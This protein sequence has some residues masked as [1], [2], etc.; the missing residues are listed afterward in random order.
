[1]EYVC[2]RCKQEV[3][4]TA[5]D[6]GGCGKPLA[7]IPWLAT[8]L[9]RARETT[10]AV[11]V[12]YMRR[13]FPLQMV[14]VALAWLAFLPLGAWMT[15]WARGALEREASG[16]AEVLAAMVEREVQP[17]LMDLVSSLMQV[18]V[19]AIE[20]MATGGWVLI[21]VGL[22]GAYVAV[23]SRFRVCRLLAALPAS[24]ADAAP[25]DERASRG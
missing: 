1:M 6:C 18:K 19:T 4:R 9:W 23:F 5:I 17:E 25:P 24:T 22:M 10:D 16:Q 14:L 8:P 21:I 13:I 2:W 15:L 7:P 20:A 3:G 11:I 12:D